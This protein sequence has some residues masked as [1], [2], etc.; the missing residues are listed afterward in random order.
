MSSLSVTV[1]PSNAASPG[2]PACLL[3][4]V[5]RH[6][7]VAL[8]P[9]ESLAQT[10]PRRAHARRCRSHRRRSCR[11]STP[12]VGAAMQ[13]HA[14]LDRHGTARKGPACAPSSKATRGATEAET[15]TGRPTASHPSRRMGNSGRQRRAEVGCGQEPQSGSKSG[16]PPSFNPWYL[17]DTARRVT[18]DTGCRVVLVCPHTVLRYRS[19]PGRLKAVALVTGVGRC[20]TGGR[21][22]RR[23]PTARRRSG[24]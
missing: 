2:Q 4:A 8:D 5:E 19:P 1:R 23:R 9:A 3:G 20:R 24:R 15:T 7:N 22:P 17:A 6:F 13:G 16:D 14:P 12:S 21:R 11:G 10:S 18:P